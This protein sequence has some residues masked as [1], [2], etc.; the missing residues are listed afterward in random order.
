MKKNVREVST[1]AKTKG[2]NAVDIEYLSTKNLTHSTFAP[3]SEEVKTLYE[4]KSSQLIINTLL[5]NLNNQSIS[6]KNEH[7]L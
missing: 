5:E 2:I 3:D 6:N 7:I 4:G 1:D